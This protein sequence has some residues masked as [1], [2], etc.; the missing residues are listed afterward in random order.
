MGPGAPP[1]PPPAYL[2]ARPPAPPAR[3]CLAAPPRPAGRVHCAAR[4]GQLQRVPPAPEGRHHHQVL[5][6]VLPALHTQEPRWVGRHYA[7]GCAGCR[8]EREG[9]K[10]AQWQ[11]SASPTDALWYP[12]SLHTACLPACCTPPPPTPTPPAPPQ[13]RGI[14]SALAAASALARGTSRTFTSHEENVGTTCTPHP[15]DSYHCN[16]QPFRRVG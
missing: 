9:R 10:K 3:P 1:P 14:A 16:L 2:P 5:A 12:A 4:D 13:T 11:P 6:H 7:R 15:S 8:L